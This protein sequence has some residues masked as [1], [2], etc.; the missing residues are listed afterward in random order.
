MTSGAGLTIGEPTRRDILDSIRAERVIWWGRL[1]E[2]AFLSRIYNLKALPST[3]VRF[4]N[5]MG[6]IWQH[7]INNDD[8]ELDW[9]LDDDRFGLHRGPDHVFLRF[10]CEM[11]HPVV[12]TD[13]EESERLVKFFNECLAIDGWELV[14]ERL[15]LGR[16]VFSP[17][18]R[19]L[20]RSGTIPK[21]LRIVLDEGVVNRTVARMDKAVGNDPVLAI[22]TAKEFVETVCK[23]ILQDR[24]VPYDENGDV[25]Y[26][27]R[28]TVRE[29][30]LAPEGIPKAARGVE[31]IRRIL[32]NLGTI[33]VGLAE[34]R[35]LYG[36]GHGGAP[37]T[38][39][40]G[41]RHA[42]L[43]VGA[44]T[45]LG[46]FLFETHRERAMISGPK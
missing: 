17:S 35:N 9:V 23:W 30:R 40:L 19:P 10:L 43:A 15:L 12:R 14:E 20:P 6:D 1:D 4:E 7:R 2:L 22:G 44:A 24:R 42:Q 39:G 28:S 21:R 27:V 29:L 11:L 25:Q 34:L 31:T 36:T 13:R 33:A 32:S 46:L 45:A 37:R 38:R 41:S 8:W 5:A 26:L 18:R 3:D 16:P